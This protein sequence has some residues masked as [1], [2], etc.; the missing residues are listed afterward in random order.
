MIHCL[1]DS[2]KHWSEKG[3]VY[4][5]SDPHFDDEDTK[6][7]NPNWIDPEEQLK[8]L[9][10]KIHKTDT[11]ICLGDCGDLEYFRRLKAG[12]KILIKGNHDDKG[13]SIYKKEIITKV[14][15]ADEIS[16]KEVYEAL[17]NE[18]PNYKID[19]YEGFEFHSP[20][21]RWIATIDNNLFDEVYDGAL[22]ISDKIV[23]SH[24]PIYGLKFALNIHGHV[25]NGEY[26]YLDKD[27]CKHLNLAC[28]VAN[29]TPIELGKL[30][31]GGALSDISTIHRLVI[32][33]AIEN[34]IHKN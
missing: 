14:F 23:L 25:H 2:F 34:P 10:S 9:N 11:F 17:R 21:H 19:V 22:F 16:R 26:E 30:I 5:L 29:Y 12:R 1:Y 31:K 13:N 33:R 7:M 24:E 18:Y 3:G 32:D 15:D 20:F 4:I 6:L 8:I 27:G 28:D